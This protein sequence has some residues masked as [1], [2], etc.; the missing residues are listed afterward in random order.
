MVATSS[1]TNMV[2]NCYVPFNPWWQPLPTYPVYYP[3]YIPTPVQIAPLVFETG[4]TK[5]DFD[6]LETENREL[7]E[8]VERLLDRLG[9]DKGKGE[10]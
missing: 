7:R 2:E 6:R 5:A 10:K 8:R 3:V 9:D 1:Q 4:P